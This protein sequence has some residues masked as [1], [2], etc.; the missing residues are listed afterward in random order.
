MFAGEVT[1]KWEG[2][3]LDRQNRAKLVVLHRPDSAYFR[4]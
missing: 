2:W 1:V 4:S 3:Q